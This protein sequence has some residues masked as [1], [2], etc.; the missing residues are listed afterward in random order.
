[1]G[2]RGI[3]R[4]KPQPKAPKEQPKQPKK[5]EGVPMIPKKK[6]T[7]KGG[8][9][10]GVGGVGGGGIQ[11]Q[12]PKKPQ[13]LEDQPKKESKTL[14]IGGFY[15]KL[16]PDGTLRRIGKKDDVHHMT[17]EG[18]EIKI[19]KR[20]FRVLPNGN[21]I[22]TVPKLDPDGTLRRIGKKDDVHHMTPEGIEIKIG[23]RQFR[24]LPNGNVI[25]TVPKPKKEENK[26]PISVQVSE[27][28][29][30]YPKGEK[31]PGLELGEYAEYS[32]PSIYV[33]HRENNAERIGQL[34]K[35]GRNTIKL[36]EGEKIPGLELGEYAE[37]SVPSIY[38][39]H[40]EN[41]AER[42][43]QL[44]KQG[45]NTIKLLESVGGKMPSDE[46][47]GDLLR[48][49]GMSSSRI[50]EVI[51]LE[52]IGLHKFRDEAK[53]PFSEAS[54]RKALRDTDIANGIKAHAFL[55]ADSI[56]YLQDNI[57]KDATGL[58]SGFKVTEGVF[59][60]GGSMSRLDNTYG[61]NI[62]RMGAEAFGERVGGLHNIDFSIPGVVTH[63]V[64][65]AVYNKMH[66]K[67]GYAFDDI[68]ENLYYKVKR[69]GLFPSEYSATNPSEFFAETFLGMVKY[70]YWGHESTMGDGTGKHSKNHIVY[71][72]LHHILENG[73]MLKSSDREPVR[74]AKDLIDFDGMKAFM[75]GLRN[76]KN[77]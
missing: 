43:G 64:G 11:P 50:N 33:N 6:K 77:N 12:Q 75:Q 4:K 41:N 2:G 15:Y 48:S 19:G 10:G 76:L 47:L 23:K 44:Q 56:K 14:R 60:V 27:I 71:Q 9:I 30:K 39:N 7:P 31:I 57:L 55:V 51:D 37:Y 58:V 72:A 38:V 73:G 18:I 52:T 59:G 13:E 28:V 62:N 17:P 5:P 45:R 61:I 70:K 26:K 32:V 25:E 1:M 21:V 46:E 8:E 20:Q 67:Y 36:L 22:E 69:E 65:H 42:I 68:I 54:T 63:E 16:D 35:Q 53:T 74:Q 66:K 3:K 24:V 40:R 49:I 34:Q 29:S